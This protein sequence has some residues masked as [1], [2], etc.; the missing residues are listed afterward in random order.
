MKI[1]DIIYFINCV[2][3]YY[4]FFFLTSDLWTKKQ[5]T[6]Y[7]KIISIGLLFELLALFI[8]DDLKKKS[9]ALFIIPFSWLFGAYLLDQLFWL[10]CQKRIILTRVKEEDRELLFNMEDTFSRRFD[11]KPEI[12]RNIGSLFSIL[13]FLFQLICLHFIPR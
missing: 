9:F 6:K 13:L 4:S 1:S 11:N 3:F 5:Y 8:L 2:F 12:I 10:L 7:L